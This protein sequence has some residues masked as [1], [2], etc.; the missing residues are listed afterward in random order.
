MKHWVSHTSLRVIGVLPDLEMS[1][2]LGLDLGRW[3]AAEAVHEPSL[4]VLMWVIVSS[5]AVTT[6]Y[7]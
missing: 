6:R 7:C 1:V 2:V 3:T 4:V 5:A